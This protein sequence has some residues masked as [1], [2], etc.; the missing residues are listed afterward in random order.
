MPQVASH[1]RD[2][3]LVP[4]GLGLPDSRTWRYRNHHG[5][6]LQVSSHSIPCSVTR[7]NENANSARC[8]CQAP[9]SFGA[10]NRMRFSRGI[11]GIADMNSLCRAAA[12]TGR[13]HSLAGH[14]HYDTGHANDESKGAH[15]HRNDEKH[16]LIV[17]WSVKELHKQEPP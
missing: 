15:N 3:G 11:A 14:R 1:S 6:S 7:G 8:T 2:L 16:G 5:P 4:A 17:G 12:R 9:F 10:D 13:A